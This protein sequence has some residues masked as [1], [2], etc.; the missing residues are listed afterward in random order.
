[1]DCQTTLIQTVAAT[2]IKVERNDIVVNAAKP[3]IAGIAK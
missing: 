1:L 3:F 2:I